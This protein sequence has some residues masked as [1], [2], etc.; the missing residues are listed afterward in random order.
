[1]LAA[2][3]LIAIVPACGGGDS[4]AERAADPISWGACKDLVRPDGQPPASA[5]PA[6]QCATLPVPLDYA[7]PDGEKLD[8]A[9]IRVR[10]TGRQRLG[11]LVF[12]FGGPGA[13]GVDTLAQA[14]KSFG[15]LNARYDL[16]SF[17]PRGVERS[18]GVKCGTG[19]D[20]DAYTSLDTLPAD[21]ATRARTEAANK[22]FAALCQQDSGK[23][24]PYVGTVNA[25]RDMD[26]LRDALGDAKL[27][28][29]GMSYG[30]QLGAVYATL[31]PELSGRL[32]LDAPLDPSVSFEQRTLVQTA[33]FQK[34]YESFLADCVKQGCELGATAK[35]ANRKVEALMEKLITQP[36]TVDGRKLTQGLAATGV[37]AALYSEYSWPLLEEALKMA[38]DGDGSALLYLADSYI[39]RQED[40]S[41]NTQMSS[42]PAITCVDS[43]ERPDAA[44]LLRTE[45]AALKISPLFGGAG[46]G[47]ICSVWPVPGSDQAR[48]VD[49]TGSG[50]ILV[51]AGKGDPA[52]PYEWGPKL[53]AQLKTAVLLTYEGEGHGAYVSGDECV[54]SAVNA[55]LLDGKVP[56]AG[57]SCPA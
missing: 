30:T 31:F 14:A 22:K 41:Y 17:D 51:V 23:V 39:G 18:A 40:G 48:H 55:Y 13:S 52:T 56:A 16:V 36:L 43:A 49:A 54:R 1:M 37:A 8:V 47:A 19:A 15:E 53:T 21:A 12:N 3:V 2:C 38:M 4:Q 29:F 24:L 5:D 11:S 6:Q 10:A 33:G 42:F 27:N 45:E 46:A 35:V 57:T 7:K 26:R 9:I 44:T 20:M 32:V 50:P 25:A 34:A 28:Y